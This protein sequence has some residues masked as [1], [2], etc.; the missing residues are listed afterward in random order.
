M[1]YDE[2]EDGSVSRLTLVDYKTATGIGRPLQLQV[3]AEAG[4]RE[5]LAVDNAF[6]EDM[7]AGQRQVV[8]VSAGALTAAQETVLTSAV[9]LRVGDFTAKPEKAKCGLC[10]VRRICAA[11]ASKRA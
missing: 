3:Y 2:A 1:I 8:D 6:I 10:D 9:A 4:L 5:D 11:S 7:R